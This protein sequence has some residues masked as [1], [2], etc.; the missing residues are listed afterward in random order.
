[1]RGHIGFIALGVLFVGAAVYGFMP[2]SSGDTTD[3][4]EPSASTSVA[5]N[6]ESTR[7]GLSEKPAPQADFDF[8][9]LAL[10]W[11]PTFCQDAGAGRNRDQCGRDKQF[12][13]V[14]HGLW[15]QY[16]QGYP[17]SCDTSQPRQG[18]EGVGRRVMDIMP[19]MG[20][21]GH[22]WR[23]HGTCSGLAMRDYFD[24]VR[25]ARQTVRIPPDFDDVDRE[26]RTSPEAIEAAFIKNNPGLTRSGVAVT[27]DRERLDEV[28]ICLTTDLGF[29]ACPEVDGRS[30]R[31]SQITIPPVP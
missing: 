31:R 17:E 14:V 3:R 18:P 21:I 8:Y 15:P 13:W 5:S 22:Q 20:L 12:G 16:E 29:R 24:L 26:T 23:K 1:M 10:S 25:E 4:A 2:G 11:S 30:C 27:C 6:S 9:V 19:G 7:E 28:R